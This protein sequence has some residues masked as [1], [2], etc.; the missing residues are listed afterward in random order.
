MK[1][2]SVTKTVA[3]KPTKNQMKKPAKKPIKKCTID[4]LI[5]ENNENADLII[6]YL[7]MIIER[8]DKIIQMGKA[9]R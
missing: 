9:F 6:E 3:K 4:D 7:K 1:K 2:K 5:N 8:L